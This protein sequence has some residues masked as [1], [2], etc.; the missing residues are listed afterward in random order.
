MHVLQ[1]GKLRQSQR[2]AAQVQSA[3]HL[4]LADAV[5]AA[6]AIVAE[7][8][9]V[10][11]GAI[12]V[13]LR[14]VDSHNIVVREAKC[15]DGGRRAEAYIE[16]LDLDRREVEDFARLKG[17]VGQAVDQLRLADSHVCLCGREAACLL[18]ELG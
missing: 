15:G 6:Q 14:L 16:V 11:G 12:V 10:Q 5:Q 17:L 7:V 3:E 2:V 18:G 4:V 13:E 9:V 1:L 8:E